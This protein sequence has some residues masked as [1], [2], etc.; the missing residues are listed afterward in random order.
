MAHPK[1]RCIEISPP[2][3]LQCRLTATL[4]QRQLTLGKQASNKKGGTR[5][6]F[7]VVTRAVASK[8]AGQFRHDIEEIADETDICNLEDRCVF[9][10]VDRD[11]G[12]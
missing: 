1:R 3:E 11:D 5:A 12:L 6:A 9:I 10:L 8:L 2:N 7:P 4:A